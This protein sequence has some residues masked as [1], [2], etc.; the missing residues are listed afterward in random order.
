MTATAPARTSTRLHVVDAVR[1][2]AVVCMV[3]WHTADSW[4]DATARSGTG[5][6]VAD[7]IGGLAAPFFFLLAGLS[8]GLSERSPTTG[9]GALGSIRRALGI[10]VAGYGLRLW[11][12]GVDW[13]AIIQPP[14]AQ[15]VVLLVAGLGLT[16]AGLSERPSAPRARAA[17]VLGGLVLVGV[18]APWLEARDARLA[19]RLDV[20]QGIGAALVLVVLVLAASSRASTGVRIAVPA[21][22]ALAVA[23]TAPHVLALAPPPGP[24][25]LWDYVA[26]FDVAPLA[27]G[28]R[29]PLVPWL[30]YALLGAAMGR[31]L[32]GRAPVGGAFGLP[33]ARSAPALLVV[34]AIISISVFE[35][36]PLSPS[37]LPH[38]QWLRNVV[39]LTFY[40]AVATG[41]AAAVAAFVPR[42]GRIAEALALLGRHSLV[43][44]A[45]HLEIAY[46]LPG[47]VI[48][49]SLGWASWGLGAAL[50]L[51]AMG[52]LAHAI[53]L[54]E[55]RRRA[56]ATRQREIT[57]ERGA[58]DDAHA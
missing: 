53:E 12:W 54:F 37:W 9:M 58:H 52:A 43:I 47:S 49:R 8:L 27:S 5:F 42:G 2:A 45:V 17:L 4:L 23:L 19:F 7:V 48:M 51:L 1:G 56:A 11:E 14:R 18:T 31:A 34:A 16:Y 41:I 24:L 36:G 13:S 10:V 50:L 15:F 35:S 22:L 33:T 26:R 57:S 3:G 40:A 38:A 25:R 28:A 21:V 30:G 39:R 20:L 46:G 6:W 55:T 29:F 44:Y 32:R